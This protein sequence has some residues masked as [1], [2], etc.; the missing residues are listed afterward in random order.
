MSRQLRL[1]HPALDFW[2]EVTVH[3][4]DGRYMATTTEAVYLR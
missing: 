4:R 3:E 1:T 2:V